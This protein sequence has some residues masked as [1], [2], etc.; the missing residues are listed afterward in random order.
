[1][2]LKKTF[3]CENI[4]VM[5]SAIELYV[6]QKV[7]EYRL[8]NNWSYKYLGDCINVSGSFIH[9]AES[10]NNETKFNLNH[11]DALA[12][13]FDCSIWKLLPEYSVNDQLK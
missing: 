10:P 2:S 3:I 1:M 5:K 4:K 8:K 7:R 6:S 9:A 11:I 12:R 13:V